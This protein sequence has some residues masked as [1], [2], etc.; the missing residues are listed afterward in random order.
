[1]ISIRYK[2]M[3]YAHATIA[4]LCIYSALFDLFH[5]RLTMLTPINLGLAAL[6]IWMGCNRMEGK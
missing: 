2:I 5:E 3:G 4:G 1:M 6:N